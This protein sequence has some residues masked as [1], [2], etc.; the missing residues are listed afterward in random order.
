MKL[1]R[2][3]GTIALKNGSNVFGT[4]LGVDM[5]MNTYLKSAKLTL[6]NGESISFDFTTIR[7]QYFEESIDRYTS[8]LSSENNIRY[9]ILPDSLSL[10]TLLVDDASKAKPKRERTAPSSLSE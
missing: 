2:E 9:F 7:G 8:G 4:V 6:K 5:S 1:T 10:D 3:S